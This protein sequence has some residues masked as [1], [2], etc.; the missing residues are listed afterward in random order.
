VLAA[1][2]ASRAT[3]SDI[4]SDGPTTTA[5]QVT[6]TKVPAG[7]VLRVGDQL[8]Y[9][10]TVL[11][12]AGQDTKFPYKVDYSAFIG[13]PPMLQ[14]F[15]AD[16]IDTGFVGS[17][18][19]IFAQAGSQDVTAVA[20]WASQHGS[21]GLV[22]AP[23]QKGIT[24]WADLKGHTV[25]Y[26]SGTAGE[27]V[28]LE[29]LDSAGLTLKDITPVNLPQTQV[30]AALQGGSADAAVQTEPLTSAYLAA[31]PTA[32][33]V[34]D[35]SLITDRSDFVIA[36]RSTLADPG[37]TAALADYVNRLVLSFKYLKSHPDQIAT[38]VY[39]NTYKLTPERATQLVRQSG[40]IGFVQLPG[41]IVKAQQHLADLFQANGEI[42]A[43]VD[44]SR[45]F[46]P[47]FNA[48]V[49][50]AQGS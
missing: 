4:S 29:A 33:Q 25:A 11:K 17:T 15:Q 34:D 20:G 21:Y 5:A 32:K 2:C 50:K 19:L 26:Q 42:P 27:A 8:D 41:D 6:L 14:A 7:T 31:N 36:A 49:Q 46:D 1:S 12:L 48:L 13:G 24:K 39:V 28:L 47:R 38:A 40:T 9:L 23:G 30:S 35:T 16:A 18:P 3:A 45:E 44:V 22:T 43:K 10:K 37:K